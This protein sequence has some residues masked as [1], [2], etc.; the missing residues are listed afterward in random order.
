MARISLKSMPTHRFEATFGGRRMPPA[1]AMV[2][3]FTDSEHAL[4]SVGIR[5]NIRSRRHDQRPGYAARG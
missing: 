1:D 2:I 4:I 5:R 3:G